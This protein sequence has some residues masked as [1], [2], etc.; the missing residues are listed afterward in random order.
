MELRIDDEIMA[1]IDRAIEEDLAGGVDVT[2]VATIEESS[3]STADF[4][5][6]KDGVIAGLAIAKAVMERCGVASFQAKVS[7][8]DLVTAGTVIATVEGVTRSILLA[9]RSALNFISRLSG[10]ATLTRAWVEAIKGSDTKIRDTR[11]TTPGL[12][13]LEKYAVR[14][15]GGINHRSTLSEA[16]LLKDNHIAAAGSIKEAVASIRKRFPDVEIEVEVDS[17]EQLE[18][19]LQ[20]EVPLILLDNMSPEMTE[21]AVLINRNRAKLESSGG[22]RLENAREYASTGV[23][24][25]AIGALTHSAPIL[26]ISLDLLSSGEGNR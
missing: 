17:L 10:I 23:D 18:E 13:S 21:K 7:D 6:K 20:A 4:V 26:D 15:G 8:G 12:R 2:S 5:V 3:R 19:A 24:F 11:K 14:V 25:L 1:L 9:E 16:A 22:I